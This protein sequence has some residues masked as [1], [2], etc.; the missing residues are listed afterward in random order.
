V[1]VDLGASCYR[2][3]YY[4]QTSGIFQ[5]YI[6]SAPYGNTLEELHKGNV[7]WIWMYYDDILFVK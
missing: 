2:V 5:T 1:L 7:Y 6:P 4:N 3:D